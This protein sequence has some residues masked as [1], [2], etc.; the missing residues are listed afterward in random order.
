MCSECVFHGSALVSVCVCAHRGDAIVLHVQ[1][2]H[3]HMGPGV[4]SV[5]FCMCEGFGLSDCG[6]RPPQCLS[7]LPPPSLNLIDSLCLNLWG[8]HSPT[9]K[10][11]TH[12]TWIG[13]K[14]LTVTKYSLF[15]HNVGIYMNFKFTSCQCGFWSG[16]R[17]QRLGQSGG[18]VG[19]GGRKQPARFR[20][21][22]SRNIF[23]FYDL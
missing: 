10:Q 15:L 5:L 23:V 8:R 12:E 7:S 4:A 1:Q 9:E 6:E 14:S 11:V 21:R 17:Q 20:N 22:T 18:E 16:E 2:L 19:W 13:P 3:L